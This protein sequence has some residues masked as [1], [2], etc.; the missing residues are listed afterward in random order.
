MRRG[1]PKNEPVPEHSNSTIVSMPQQSL[2]RHTHN[3]AIKVETMGKVVGLSL[4]Q[5]G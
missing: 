3:T 2:L 5:G 1:P 4:L